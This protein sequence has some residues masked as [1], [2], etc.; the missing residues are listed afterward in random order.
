MIG[1]VDNLSKGTN[2]PE[3]LVAGEGTAI[4]LHIK[5]RMSV[6]LMKLYC[7]LFKE[8]NS[9]HRLGGAGDNLVDL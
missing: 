1:H 6:R 2:V 8:S 4:T 7:D 3:I 9:A 5:R